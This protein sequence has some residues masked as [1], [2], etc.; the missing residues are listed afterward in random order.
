MQLLTSF[1]EW[2]EMT[3][4]RHEYK[5]LQEK[6]E[7]R[8]KKRL[9]RHELQERLHSGSAD[10]ISAVILRPVHHSSEPDLRYSSGYDQQAPYS[11]DGHP[12]A[13]DGLP[14]PPVGYA[15]QRR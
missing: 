13:G 1:K 3:E 4:M 5:E 12:Y 15:P 7:E 2:K 8:H 11:A 6:K 9:E 14:A 10:E